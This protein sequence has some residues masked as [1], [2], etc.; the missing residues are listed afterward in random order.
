M[1]LY[2]VA[3]AGGAHH[4]LGHDDVVVTL[5]VGAAHLTVGAKGGHPVT[6]RV[7]EQNK[8]QRRYQEKHKKE[9]VSARQETNLP[10]RG[11]GKAK[12]LCA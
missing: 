5:V 12:E 10:E 2:L 8:I 3:G 6:A 4:G 7:L 1:D 9:R 11:N